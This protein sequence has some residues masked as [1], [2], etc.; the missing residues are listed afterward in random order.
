MTLDHDAHQS[1]DIDLT[2][3]EREFM[4]RKR[5]VE[6]RNHF[7]AMQRIRMVSMCPPPARSNHWLARL[8]RR[9]VQWF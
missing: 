4:N 1:L 7:A 5:S 9:V 2:E 6:R 3:V 8:A